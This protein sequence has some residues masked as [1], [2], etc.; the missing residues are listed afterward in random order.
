MRPIWKG[1]LTF[2]L[3]TIPVGMYP[4]T[5]RGDLSFRLLHA[6]DKSPIAYRRVC[7]E[8]N[9]EVPWAE[10]VKGYE[11]EKGPCTSSSRTIS[12]RRRPAPR[13]TRC[14]A[15]R[16]AAAGVSGWPL[17]CSASAGTSRPCR[18]RARR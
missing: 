3:V 11:Y 15:K 1:A 2:G 5:A 7:A 9:V 14:C 6:N 17:S 16:C 4:A 18:R 10:I 12:S 13:R 8:E